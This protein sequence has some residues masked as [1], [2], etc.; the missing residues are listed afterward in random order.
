M[1]NTLRE[2]EHALLRETGKRLGRFGFSTRPKGQTFYRDIDGGRV[3]VHLSFIEHES[4]VDVTVDVAIRFD[5]VEELVHRSNK[6]LSKREKAETFTLGAELGNLEHGEP[7]RITVSSPGDVGRAAEGIETKLQT[8]GLPYMERYS[9]PEAT[10]SLLSKD[11]GEV[12]VHSPIH[13]ERAK[14]ACALL[15]VM[16]RHSEINDLG[17]KKLSFL[18]SVNDQGAAAFSRFLAELQAG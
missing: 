3:G 17:A 9:Q 13:A 11:D 4:D 8:V 2:L 5:A 7:F 15:A 10:Y 12:W 18:E 16:D 14:R 1:T 6:L